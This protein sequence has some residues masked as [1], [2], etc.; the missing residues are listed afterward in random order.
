[1]PARTC[2]NAGA[3]R[4]TARPSAMDPPEAATAAPAIQGR[5]RPPLRRFRMRP[6]IG[7]AMM[8]LTRAGSHAGDE[9][10]PKELPPESEE[11]APQSVHAQDQASPSPIERMAVDSVRL[12]KR[13]CASMQ[14]TDPSWRRSVLLCNGAS[15]AHFAR[16]SPPYPLKQGVTLCCEGSLNS[17]LKQGMGPVLGPLGWCRIVHR[18]CGTIAWFQEEEADLWNRD[19]EDHPD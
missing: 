18:R 11:S 17:P 12:F 10:T 2:R 14:V 13:N 4:N 5:E 9:P 7:S 3:P 15:I 1:M 6:N 16:W 19:W 8:Q